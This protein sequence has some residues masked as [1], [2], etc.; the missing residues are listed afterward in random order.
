MKSRISE[1]FWVIYDK[2]QQE[3]ARKTSLLYEHYHP[4]IKE[5]NELKAPIIVYTNEE[6]L[7][8]KWL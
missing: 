4:N 3:T 6:I 1:N 7:W 2:Y 5:F 8:R